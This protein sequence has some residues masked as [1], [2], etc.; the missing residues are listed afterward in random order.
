MT[1]YTLHGTQT[2]VCDRLHEDPA[3]LI[4]SAS[5]CVRAS[6]N[7]TYKYAYPATFIQKSLDMFMPKKMDHLLGEGEQD[8]FFYTGEKLGE[9][10][11]GVFSVSSQNQILLCHVDPKYLRK[12]VGTALWRTFLKAR[13]PSTLSV[14]APLSSIN[15]FL[16]K[17]FSLAQK[18]LVQSNPLTSLPLMWS[19]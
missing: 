2:L 5:T 1:L 8:T 7:Q 10:V 3:P 4:K 9:T 11:L 16:T 14:D 18:D 13:A 17:G 6:I 19:A 12:G 15:W